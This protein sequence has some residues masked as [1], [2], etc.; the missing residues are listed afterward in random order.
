MVSARIL[1]DSVGYLET[2]ELAEKAAAARKGDPKAETSYAT[3][4]E[5][6]RMP[7]S[8]FERLEA[9]GAVEKAGKDAESAPAV[10]ALPAEQT[11][12]PGHASERG[13]AGG[14][15]GDFQAEG[16]QP[17]GVSGAGKRGIPAQGEPTSS[18][19][20]TAEAE[21][22]EETDATETVPELKPLSERSHDE[23]NALAATLP[24]GAAFRSSGNRAEKAE[25]LK[26]AGLTDETPPAG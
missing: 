11:G 14:V 24:E 3:K 5:V 1:F 10:D 15:S 2:E 23:L 18:P 17:A 26:A 12:A 13:G 7:A 19:E 6:V 22:S 9:L 16:L 21:T 8:E 4:G 20:P 25:D